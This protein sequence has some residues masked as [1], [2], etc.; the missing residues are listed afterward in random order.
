MTKPKIYEYEN[1]DERRAIYR[2]QDKIKHFIKYWEKHYNIKVP[3][4]KIQWFKAN[5]PVIKKCL[6][7]F[8]E[9]CNIEFINNNDLD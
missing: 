4:E 6:P 7:I 2:E 9:L 1:A 8:K 5:K 3:I